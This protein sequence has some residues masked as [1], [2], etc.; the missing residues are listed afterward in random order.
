[1][2]YSKVVEARFL[3][4]LNRFVARVLL[5]GE[6]HMVHVKNTGRCRELL[7]PGAAVY[8]AAAENPNRKTAFDLIAV[9][10]GTLLVNMDSQAPNRVFHE[11]AAQGGFLPGVTAIHPEYTFGDSRYDFYVEQGEIRHLVEIKG[12]TLEENGVARFPDAPTERGVKHIN[13]LIAAREQGYECTIC[14]VVQMS[15][16]N[17]LEPND[18][19]HP[20]FGEALRRAAAAG[21]HVMAVD[22]AATTDS[23]SIGSRVPVHLMS[24]GRVE[25]LP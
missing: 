3:S 2:H 19:T 4:R 15:P 6:E 5:N 14:F 10:K 16:V 21:V 25:D 18:R 24:G 20:A 7:T 23:L 9:Q 13:G 11:W 17:W 1:M 22:C 8:L 12:V